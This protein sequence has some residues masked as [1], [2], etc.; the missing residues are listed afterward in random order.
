MFHVEH[1]FS[2]LGIFLFLWQPSRM[3][4]VQVRRTVVLELSDFLMNRLDRIN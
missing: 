4:G 1:P 3:K 2:L